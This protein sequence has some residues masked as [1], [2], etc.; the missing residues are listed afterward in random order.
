VIVTASPALA[1]PGDG[2]L[3]DIG[4]S[5]STISHD[6]DPKFAEVCMESAGGSGGVGIDI[7]EWRVLT[8]F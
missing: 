6:V 5:A 2:R 7:R 1:E 4:F 8:G 3:E